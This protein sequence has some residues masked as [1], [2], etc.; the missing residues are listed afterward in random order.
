[1]TVQNT[2]T[3][4]LSDAPEDER[5]AFVGR[6]LMLLRASA[7]R[8][9]ALWDR[10]LVILTDREK[11]VTSRADFAMWL[12]ANALDGPARECA[13]RRVPHG[14]V[15]AWLEADNAIGACAGFALVNLAGEIERLRDELDGL[16]E[17]ARDH[18][19]RAG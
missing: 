6:T 7:F 10:A 18:E 12:R 11:R 5:R 8:R 3:L 1:M 14:H 15:L 9:R 4:D 2:H 19:E 17:G 13:S 16:D